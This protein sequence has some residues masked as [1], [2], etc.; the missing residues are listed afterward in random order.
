MVAAAR[1]QLSAAMDAWH[2]DGPPDRGAGTALPTLVAHGDL[3]VV[4]PLANAKALATRWPGAGVEV[5]AGCGH[6]L[7]AQEP[8][9]V[10][11]LIAA[12]ADGR[13]R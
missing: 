5:L 6:A 7:M 2:R 9:R 3:D 12:L 4:I 11:D 10:A 1:A 13:T 8:L